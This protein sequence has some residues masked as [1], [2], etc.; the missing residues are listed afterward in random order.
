MYETFH[1]AGSYGKTASQN[2]TKP[3]YQSSSFVVL[4]VHT[5][6]RTAHEY[7]KNTTYVHLI[8]LLR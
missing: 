6:L 8:Y 4:Q 7:F 2:F 3:V 5:F 1:N